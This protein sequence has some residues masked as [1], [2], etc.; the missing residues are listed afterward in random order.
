[1]SGKLTKTAGQAKRLVGKAT[2]RRDLAARGRTQEVKGAVKNRATR[3]GR[4]VR[5]TVERAEA[6]IRAH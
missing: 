1:M 6:R 2:G 5:R 3:A 4:R